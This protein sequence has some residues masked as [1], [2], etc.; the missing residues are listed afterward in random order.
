MR[1]PLLIATGASLCAVLLVSMHAMPSPHGFIVA[2]QLDAIRA[3]PPALEI[4]T[5]TWRWHA[6]KLYWTGS[7]G[8]G[9]GYYADLVANPGERPEEYL[10][11]QR[12]LEQQR[13][14]A[15][16]EGDLEQEAAGPKSHRLQKIQEENA[17]VHHAAGLPWHPE[18]GTDISFI[19]T[20]E[21]PGS[22]ERV[23][24]AAQRSIAR[25]FP[26]QQLGAKG[27]A[28]PKPLQPRSW[29]SV[30]LTP[31]A[32]QSGGGTAELLPPPQKDPYMP[33]AEE[34][35]EKPLH[36]ITANPGRGTATWNYG[37]DAGR[38]DFEDRDDGSF[39]YNFVTVS[40]K[41]ARTGAYVRYIMGG[42]PGAVQSDAAKAAEAAAKSKAAANAALDA[43]PLLRP[44][45]IFCSAASHPDGA[46][47]PPCEVVKAVPNLE[48]DDDV[49]D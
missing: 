13:Q 22:M 6:P 18:M 42:P 48:M 40:P 26:V 41:D 21:F 8:G 38:D 14:A 36:H 28:F 39:N 45:K 31:K 23:P 5:G 9:A 16:Q 47:P 19:P 35:T 46:K 17:V 10:E 34:N 49:Y 20:A 25:A 3:A 29:V 12:L 7:T 24:G 15:R 27:M 43:E 4:R 11:K 1:R 33:A 37:A 30:T 32:V 2:M 44:T